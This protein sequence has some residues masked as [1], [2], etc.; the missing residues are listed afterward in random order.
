MTDTTKTSRRA[1]LAGVPAAALVTA[2][3][4][5]ADALGA[6]PMGL[7]G[8]AELLSLKPEVDD[9]LGEW[10]RQKTEDCLRHQELEGLHLAKFGF[11]RDGAP[12][13]DWDDPEYVA[14]VRALRQLIHEFH[15]G[16]SDDEADLVH[17]DRIN[18]KLDPL[19][20][21]V[22][23]CKASTLEGLRL[24][25]R[26]LIIYHAEI[27]NPTFWTETEPN[28]PKMFALFASLC[29]VLGVP[30]PPVPERFQA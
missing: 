15:S 17:W 25:T 4:A 22:L 30:F 16:D 23:S 13:P 10:I 11:G 7:D 12:E 20:E 19:A 1:L 5:L 9:V 21:K 14:Y 29:G 8:D 2:A 26:V 28:E 24:Q 27:W 6:A 3:P 18:D